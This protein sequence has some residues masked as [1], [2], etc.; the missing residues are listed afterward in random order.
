[1][2]KRKRHKWKQPLGYS[3]DLSLSKQS[4]GNFVVLGFSHRAL[5]GLTTQPKNRDKY[6]ANPD[7]K[8]AFISQNNMPQFLWSNYSKP[9]LIT[10]IFY[11]FG[12]RIYTSSA[13]H[14]SLTINHKELFSNHLESWNYYFNL[15]LN[16]INFYRSAT[17]VN[18]RT[19]LFAYLSKV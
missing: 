19:N 9:K 3:L 18:F 8:K 12:G 10:I 5:N 17:S 2:K 15:W 14:H 13:F 1:M 11:H 6:I 4:F 16:T 7:Q